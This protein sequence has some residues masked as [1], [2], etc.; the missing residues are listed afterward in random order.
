MQPPGLEAERA[1]RLFK[2]GL[3]STVSGGS[4]FTG[5]IPGFAMENTDK[6][7]KRTVQSACPTLAQTWLPRQHPR[8]HGVTP[9]FPSPGRGRGLAAAPG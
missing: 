8:S 5:D 7:Q 6:E 1:V 4:K 3:N 2:P 9:A